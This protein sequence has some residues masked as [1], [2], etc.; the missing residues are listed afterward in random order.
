MANGRRQA[1]MDPAP[2][3]PA[4]SQDVDKHRC[5]TPHHCRVIDRLAATAWSIRSMRQYS[6]V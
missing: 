1:A 3:L 5:Y 2:Q 4:A 6:S